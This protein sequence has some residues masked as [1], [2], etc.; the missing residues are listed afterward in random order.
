MP[1]PPVRPERQ[2]PHPPLKVL[3]TRVP[4]V[5]LLVVCVGVMMATE[6]VVVMDKDPYSNLVVAVESDIQ[7]CFA[8]LQ[9]TKQILSEASTALVEASDGRLAFTKVTFL[10]P[11]TIAEECGL[12]GKD[13]P[14]FGGQP[15]TLQPQGCGVSGSLLYLPYS[16]LINISPTARGKQVLH[17]WAKYRWGVFEEYGVAGDPV[18]SLAYYTVPNLTTNTSPSWTPN[19]C[20]DATLN[21]TFKEP[22]DWPD[23]EFEF[24]AE[25]AAQSSLMALPTLSSVSLF[26]D[27]TTHQAL[28]PTKH[29]AR[30][31]G[32]SVAE[33]LHA[34][35]DFQRPMQNVSVDG[36]VDV[37]YVRYDPGSEGSYVLLVEMSYSVS[38]DIQEGRWTLLRSAIKQW[39]L[40]DVVEGSSLG[41]VTF[42]DYFD[43]PGTITT[44]SSLTVVTSANRLGLSNALPYSTTTTSRSKYISTALSYV[45]DSMTS[46]SVVILVTFPDNI[47]SYDTE[48]KLVEAAG[49]NT[50][51][52]VLYTYNND[53]VVQSDVELLQTLARETG[54]QVVTVPDYIYQNSTDKQSLRT[55]LSLVQLLRHITAASSLTPDAPP[56]QLQVSQSEANTDLATV[57]VFV[58][59]NVDVTTDLTIMLYSQSQPVSLTVNNGPVSTQP[60]LVAGTAY[61]ILQTFQKGHNQLTIRFTDAPEPHVTEVLA[62][63]AVGV[64]V[65]V[66]FWAS[67][68]L[69]FLYLDDP[70]DPVT[71]YVKVSDVGGRAVV[72]AEV[73]VEARSGTTSVWLHLRDNGGGADVTGNDGVYSGFW[74]LV[75]QGSGTY[76]LAVRVTPTTTSRIVGYTQP[77]VNSEGVRCCGS[78]LNVDPLPSQHFNATLYFIVG[79][80]EVRGA[81][82]L[83]QPPARI[84]DL[85]GAPLA[86]NVS[87]NFTA[88]GNDLDRGYAQKYHIYW[89]RDGSS[90]SLMQDTTY[91]LVEGGMLAQVV[92][93]PPQCNQQV[94]YKVNAQNWQTQVG[95]DSNI[96]SVIVSCDAKPIPI[97]SQVDGTSKAL[98]I[99]LSYFGGVFTVLLIALLVYL[100]YYRNWFGR[101]KESV[102]DNF[103]RGN[104]TV[105]GGHTN[106]EMMESYLTPKTQNNQQESSPPTYQ[107]P[108]PSQQNSPRLS[109]YN[110]PAHPPPPPP[111]Q[112]PHMYP[113]KD[114]APAPQPRREAF[115]LADENKPAI[116]EDT[117]NHNVTVSDTD[118]DSSN[119]IYDTAYG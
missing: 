44:E 97:P 32:R 102:S 60:T 106:Q 33:V 96:A 55:Q 61:K 54:G 29:N 21:G 93:T 41:I 10:V 56:S 28:A 88:P 80:A 75:S 49:N 30:C 46:E 112:M 16:F 5:V 115:Q 91:T 27:N 86:T 84:N 101:C 94:L 66:E 74:S 37:E 118:A 76:T 87:L 7:D 104:T 81:L 65:S 47:S 57:D 72:G 58:G 51:W 48:E 62:A 35:P 15:W 3:S 34:H 116:Y 70:Q 4:V 59:D 100:L 8:V 53:T 13:H 99:C 9:A 39:I 95:E 63:A 17:E 31:A 45:R 24:G 98:I 79:E 12:V 68:D 42:M 90:W 114:R 107:A 11:D 2:H 67:H 6:A 64:E 1:R 25:Q 109:V 108:Q 89:S 85:R 50:V 19:Y 105:S 82:V 52:P 77:V 78:A 36:G 110:A 14:M 69:S 40:E 18:F 92:F 119:T 43:Y 83:G 22:C 23:C 20:S 38:D 111:T 117:S 26:C 113:K 71:L 103:H 73:E